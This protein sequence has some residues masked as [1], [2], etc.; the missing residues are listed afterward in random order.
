MKETFFLFFPSKLSASARTMGVHSM[1][2]NSP[3]SAH[4]AIIRPNAPAKENARLH[5]AEPTSP[6]DSSTRGRT[7]STIAPNINCPLAYTMANTV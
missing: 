7:R 2:W 5:S 3:F 6:T 1:D 4:S